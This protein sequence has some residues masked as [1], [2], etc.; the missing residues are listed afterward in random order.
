MNPAGANGGVHRFWGQVSL[1]AFS[2]VVNLLD[3]FNLLERSADSWAPVKRD[4]LNRAN[5]AVL[6][7]AISRGNES[8]WT[9]KRVLFVAPFPDI[10]RDTGE[11]PVTRRESFIGRTGTSK[12]RVEDGMSAICR[13]A[14]SAQSGFSVEKTPHRK[15]AWP[16]RKPD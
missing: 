8:D 16:M 2:S 6:S 7:S 5:S 12:V 10:R 4:P 3:R 1:N 14:W 15:T 11:S 13:A 9:R